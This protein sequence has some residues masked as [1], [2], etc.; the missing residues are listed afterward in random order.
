MMPRVIERLIHKIEDD[1]QKF[2]K[3]NETIASQTNM[4]A[5]NA[6]IE[7]ARSG[8][9]GRGFIVVAN[10]VKS[11]AKQAKEN[12]DKFKSL[13]IN[14]IQ[15]GINVTEKMVQQ[16]EGGRLTDMAQTLVQI[17][18]R[19]LY[20]RTADCRWWATDEA[21]WKCLEDPTPAN[22]EHATKRLGVINKFYGVYM[23]LVLAD[24]EGNVL[25]ISRPDLFPGAMAAN[26]KREHWFFEAMKT[27]SGADYIVDDIH[28]SAIHNGNPTAVYSAAVRRGG[29]MQG[30]ALGVLGVFF[31]WGP[32]SHVIC[33]N[34][35]TLTDEEKTRS[36]VLL[37]DGKLRIIQSS[38]GQGI[39]TPFDLDTGGQQHGSYYDAQGNI[40]AFARTIGYEEYDGLGWYGVVVQKPVSQAEI[41]KKLVDDGI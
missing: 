39:Y 9:A 29:E 8:E 32:Q 14:R 31:D 4:L 1:V 33:C 20:E 40:V 12:S 17:I 34:E 36:R 7:A 16:V 13:I 2:S 21:F 19:N 26:V 11:L 24:V 41:E 18:V 25:A 30:Q 15:Y 10:E 3:D 22:R 38:D 37:L 28:N 5:L 23:N 27:H 6:T 35:P